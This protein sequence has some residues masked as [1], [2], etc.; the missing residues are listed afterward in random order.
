MADSGRQEDESVASSDERVRLRRAS[1]LLGLILLIAVSYHWHPGGGWNVM[2]RLGLIRAVVH[3]GT[4]SIN[5]NH[6][7]TGDKAEYPPGSGN[8]YSDKPIGAQV[9]G[10][11]GYLAGLH[12]A[13][14]LTPADA[15]MSPLTVAAMVATWAAVGLPTI[16]LGLLMLR[17]FVAMGLGI[18]DAAFMVVAYALGTLAWP[19]STVYYGHQPAAAFGMIGFIAAFF[20]LRAAPR[21]LFLAGTAGLMAAWAA[22]TEIPAAMVAGIVFAYV[23]RAGWKLALAYV[24]GAVPP[25]VLQLTYNW[26]CFDSPLRFGY[27]YEA[28]PAFQH[29][30]G[31]ISYPHLDALWGITFSPDKGLFFLSPLLLFAI[32]GLVRLVGDGEWR[33]EGL[34]CSVIFG[35]YLLYNASHYMWEGGVCFGPRHLVPS[36]PFLAVGLA[37]VWPALGRAL[38]RTFR[39][40]TLW[41]AFLAFAAVCTLAEPAMN[42][43][44]GRPGLGEALIR[45]VYGVAEWLNLGITLGVPAGLSFVVQGVG[46]AILVSLMWRLLAQ[47]TEETSPEPPN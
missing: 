24:I 25:I 32:W 17:L 33:P 30:T 47:S 39:I 28:N 37:G 27:M 19:Y 34:V 21:S 38:R 42:L 20:A 2:T 6:E 13:A 14:P 26:A 15:M 45:F 12:V 4:L 22:V 43:F 40:V 36:L 11:L 46:L 8:Y 44:T 16:V 41:S 10:V 3:D 1:W 31:W 23:A 35:G 7:R 9:L 18:R 29:P 5:R